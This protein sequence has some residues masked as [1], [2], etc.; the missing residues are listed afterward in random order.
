ML[1]IEDVKENIICDKKNLY[2]DFTASGL[3]YK[4]IEK[5]IGNILKTYANTHSE[6]GKHAIKT[7]EIY[8]QARASLYKNLEVN[9]DDFFILP[10][11]TGC[12]GAIKK[13]QEIAGIYLPPETKKRLDLKKVK[14][15]AYA[16]W[17]LRASFK[18]NFF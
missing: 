6:F 3:G 10:A 15:T 17:S 4:K 9:P 7:S 11:G 1:K 12:T 18:R 14:K 8:A 2:L 5:K 13:F 16:G